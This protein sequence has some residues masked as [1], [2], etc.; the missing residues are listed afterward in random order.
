MY[1]YT[2]LLYTTCTDGLYF[3]VQLDTTYAHMWCT[4]NDWISCTAVRVYCS[5]VSVH[6]CCKIVLTKES[7]SKITFMNCVDQSQLRFLCFTI[8]VTRTLNT[9]C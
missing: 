1:R 5:S 4:H 6:L 9:A 2:V 7:T 8:T 3:S